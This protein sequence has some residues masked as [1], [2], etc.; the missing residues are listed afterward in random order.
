M[1]R[2]CG[3]LYAATLPG[4]RCCAC[5]SLIERGVHRVYVVQTCCDQRDVFCR[6]CWANVVAAYV[7]GTLHGAARVN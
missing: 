7:W 5:S 3:E 4:A 6:G 1:N 2:S